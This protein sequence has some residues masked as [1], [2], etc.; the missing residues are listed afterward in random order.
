MAGADCR[1]APSAHTHQPPAYSSHLGPAL[2][3][4]LPSAPSCSPLCLFL[5]SLP[6][7]LSVFFSAGLCFPFSQSHILFVC[8][9]HPHNDPCLAFP[10]PGL[11]M[12]TAKFGKAFGTGLPRTCNRNGPA[13]MGLCP[14]AQRGHL[15]RARLT[16]GLTP[17]GGWE[18]SWG[19]LACLTAPGRGPHWARLLSGKLK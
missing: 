15:P 19:L 16:L 6:S 9:T 2:R 14:V 7:L 4:S 8:L 11:V 12:V 1:S 18:A 13:C 3:A 17:P 5:L 10:G